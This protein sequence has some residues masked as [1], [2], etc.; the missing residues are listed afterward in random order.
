LTEQQEKK[1]MTK[2]M[3]TLFTVISLF[4]FGLTLVACGG[5]AAAPVASTDTPVPTTEAVVTPTNTLLPATNTPLPPANNPSTEDEIDLQVEIA[6]GDPQIGE[7][8]ALSY[9]CFGCHVDGGQDDHYGPRFGSTEDLPQIM[10][11]GELRI[12]DPAYEGRATTNRE[13]IIESIMLPE[14]YKAPGDW[15]N[16]N[17]MPT[18]YQERM[19]D[20][21]LAD[22]LAW[23]D[24][25]E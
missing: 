6:E 18:D 23:L 14:I 7:L 19:T 24:T 21:D 17:P 3:K 4:F 16:P 1:G 13:Y 9:R 12:V 11:R 20:T 2:L 25:F 15:H 10:D 5:A 22:I 8:T